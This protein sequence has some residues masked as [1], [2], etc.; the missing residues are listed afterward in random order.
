MLRDTVAHTSS[1]GL[2]VLADV[3]TRRQCDAAALRERRVARV[4]KV[5]SLFLSSFKK[6]PHI[7]P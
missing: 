6:I 5:K 7:D 2:L 1:G 4:S 3:A